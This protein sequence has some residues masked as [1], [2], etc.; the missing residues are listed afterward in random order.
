[1]VDSDEY[2]ETFGPGTV[3]YG[4]YRGLYPTN[5]EFNRAVATRGAPASSDKGLPAVVNYAVCSGDSPNWLTISRNLP[6][7][8]EKG[9]GYQSAG[10]WMSTQRN[11]R[12]TVRIGTKIPGGVVFYD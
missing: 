2:E 7:G 8:T 5:E 3:P 12:R 9:T 10:R 1:M 11:K 4:I 6:A